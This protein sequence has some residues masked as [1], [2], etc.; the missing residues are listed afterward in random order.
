MFVYLL[1]CL[2]VSQM[3]MTPNKP[4]C[5]FVKHLSEDPLIVFQLLNEISETKQKIIFN[6]FMVGTKYDFPHKSTSSQKKELV[7]VK[8][9]TKRTNTGTY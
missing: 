2:S 8:F 6:W 1:V 5:L 4:T 7:L 3:N 9:T